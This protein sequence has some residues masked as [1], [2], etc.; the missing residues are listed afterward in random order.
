MEILLTFQHFIFCSVSCFYV[1]WY[2]ICF[3]SVEVLCFTLC[4]WC[5]VWQSP[6]LRRYCWS[7]RPGL[8]NTR[9]DRGGRAWGKTCAPSSSSYRKPWNKTTSNRYW[10][11]R[12]STPTPS[13]Q[14]WLKGSSGC[15][16]VISNRFSRWAVA[17]TFIN[18]S[19]LISSEILYCDVW[20]WRGYTLF[21]V[22][23]RTAA[24]TLFKGG[25]GKT[26]D[27]SSLK[28][29]YEGFS[30]TME[31]MSCQVGYNTITS[32]LL[33]CML[34]LFSV[35]ELCLCMEIYS[36]AMHCI[37]QEWGQ[38]HFSSVNP[39]W[40]DWIEMGIS[41]LELTVLKWNWPQ[42]WYLCQRLG[43]LRARWSPWSSISTRPCQLPPPGWMVWR[44]P[45]SLVLC[46]W[47]RTLRHSYKTR[48]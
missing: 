24:G 32:L 3:W 43:P 12:P 8:P 33:Y 37:Y 44:T 23:S 22:Y 2:C 21:Q 17:S 39:S 20:W 41:V 16:Y 45:C 18:H 38:F 19:E 42:P 11:H 26:E 14:H 30:Q 40:I 25:M 6:S 7:E 46:C 48:R 47:Q 27:T 36:S 4:F 5:V 34:S 28:T 9:W 13:R 29:L 31:E 1:M 10:P 35:V 15:N